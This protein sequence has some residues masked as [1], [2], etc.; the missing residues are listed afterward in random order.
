AWHLFGHVHGR[1]RDED[2]ANPRLLA[3]DVGV[4][5][6]GYRPVSFEE[7][8]DFLRPREEAFRT[9]RRSLDEAGSVDGT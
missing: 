2:A 3:M 4:D 9:W 8:A 6:C 5:A 7:V 1:L